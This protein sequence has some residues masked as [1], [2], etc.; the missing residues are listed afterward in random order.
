MIRY[1]LYM[2]LV[3]LLSACANESIGDSATAP[4]EISGEKPILKSEVK[5][6]AMLKPEPYVDFITNP[7]NGLTV[8]KE[9]GNFLFSVIYKPLDFVAMINLEKD[10][11]KYMNVNKERSEIAGMQYFTLKLEARDFNDELLK[12]NLNSDRQYEDR[13]NYFA[14]R[15]QQDIQLIEGKDTLNCELFHFERN[16]GAAPY[17]S[18]IL[19]F[20][21]TG[22]TN[23]IYDKTISLNEKVFGTGKVNITISKE[24]IANIPQ[25]TFE[26]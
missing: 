24:S 9:I 5:N 14:F 4:G 17:A 18:F 2:L 15:M 16:Y 8:T 22:D 10:S 3:F 25:L 19:G 6:E 13:V 11:V 26:N 7:D 12:F 20:E 1:G 23:R 21:N